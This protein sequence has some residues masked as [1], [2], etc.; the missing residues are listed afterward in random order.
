MTVK[1]NIFQK[2]LKQKTNEKITQTSYSQNNAKLYKQDIKIQ[3]NVEVFVAQ[4]L[5]NLTFGYL[6]LDFR[7]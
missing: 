1:Q 5:P 7:R 3:F 4:L 6:E 2:Y